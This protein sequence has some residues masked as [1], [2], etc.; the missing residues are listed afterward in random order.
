[1]MTKVADSSD[2]LK[3]TSETSVFETPVPSAA[4]FDVP[5][6]I[7]APASAS[8]VLA[9]SVVNER[10]PGDA[11]K[12]LKFTSR[13]LK[14]IVRASAEPAVK[15]P[16]ETEA[17]KELAR[18]I[19]EQFSNFGV[20]SSDDEKEAEAAEMTETSIRTTDSVPPPSAEVEFTPVPLLLDVEVPAGA[21][22]PNEAGTDAENS[23]DD[24]IEADVD[25]SGPSRS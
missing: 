10:V 19:K 11:P 15:E 25:I 17:S 14:P 21:A 7:D 8:S 22:R 13:S 16:E 1:M 18:K 23:D 3:S 24:T 6:G 2:R 20:V 5:D 12:D 9:G 4:E